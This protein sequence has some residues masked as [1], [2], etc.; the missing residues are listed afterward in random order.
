QAGAVRR[1]LGVRGLAAGVDDPAR[2]G[3]PSDCRR[4]AM[5]SELFWPILCVVLGLILLIGEVFIP[6]GGI[7]GLLAIGLLLVG[8]GLAFAQSTALG[9]KFLVGLLLSVP[10][11]LAYAIHVWPRTPMAKWVFLR[12]PEAEELIPEDHGPRLEHLVGQ[13]GRAL[14]P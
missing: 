9:L 6:S 2:P 13:F 3:G 1:R 8:L 11:T 14:T 7:I 4:G 12:P 10:L 5:S